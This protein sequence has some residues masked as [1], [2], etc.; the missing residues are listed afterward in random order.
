MLT[1]RKKN[2]LW[3]IG[4]S[5]A[6]ALA[7][8]ETIA[9][10][11]W[12]ESW[13]DEFFSAFRGY[14]ILTGE[15][16]PFRDGP[17]G[18]G[19]L[20]VATYSA[21]HYL[22]GPNLYAARALSAVFFLASLAMLFWISRALAGKWAALAALA[23]VLSNLLMVSIYMSATM[24]ALV[25]LL[26]LLIIRVEM[27]GRPGVRR[28]ILNGGL[29]A[30]MVLAR[31]NM[32]AAVVMYLGYL[33]VRKTPA[34]E[35]LL[36]LAVFASAVGA[37]YAPIIA[38]NPLSALSFVL[39]SFADFG[40]Y[41]GLPSPAVSQDIA[42]FLEVLT[43]FL[44]EYYGFLALFIAATAYVLWQERGRMYEFMLREPAYV[45]LAGLGAGLLAAHYFYW[46][47]AGNLFYANYFMPLV[48]LAAVVG[49]F[50]FL[51][52]ERFGYL[53]L[54]AVLVLNFG[55][56]LFRT[57]AISNPREESDLER[58][59]RG[60]AFVAA[61]TEPNA[62]LLTFDNS[63]YHVF[64]ADRRTFFPLMQR[65]FLFLPDRDTEKVRRIGFYNFAILKQWAEQDADYVLIHKE[66]WPLSLVR[67][68]FWGHAGE[69]PEAGVAELEKIFDTRYELVGTA[70]NVYP[71]KYTKGNDGGTLELYKRIK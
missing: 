23:L 64:L 14:L 69:D 19:P 61:H 63:L 25:M 12:R 20:V 46:R 41:G 50:R 68:P 39:S 22:F 15:F 42:Q 35:M 17:F 40:P 16:V 53:L 27:R 9:F 51:P 18:Y 71:R 59:R 32:I 30:V 13:G 66:Q 49:L 52:N 56:N 1:D 33:A 36:F 38:A 31:I 28:Q 6:A 58:T 47:F 60:A 3:W 43:E 70:L 48:I 5:A 29:F 21:V 8:L 67:N 55:T 62:K 2:I 7:L 4:F 34:R 54:G 45:L 65:N 26:L 44:K 10:V 57:D 37:G 11:L 24:Y